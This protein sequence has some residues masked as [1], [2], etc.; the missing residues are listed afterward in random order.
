MDRRNRTAVES[1]PAGQPTAQRTRDENRIAARSLR[2]STD[3]VTDAEPPPWVDP[4]CRQHLGSAPL[5]T[6]MRSEQMSS[7]VAVRLADGR[8]VVL[9]RRDSEGG[10]EAVCLAAQAAL[11]RRGLPVATPLTPVSTTSE[12]GREVAVHAEAWVPG[13]SIMRGD[14]PGEAGLSARLLARF[15]AGL[16]DLSAIGDP[17]P[18]PY[19]LGW[20]YGDADPWPHKPWLADRDPALVPSWVTDVAR[21]VTARIID[22]DLPRVLGHGDWEAQNLRWDSSTPVVVHDWDSLAL[23][24]EAAVVGAASGAFASAEVP[25]LAPIASSL[26]FL[27]AYQRERNRTFSDQE[28]QVAWAASLWPAAHNARGELLFGHPPVASV[29]LGDQYVARL[30]LAGA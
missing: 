12:G 8:P 23:V 18:P 28:M 25:T 19:W 15:M 27:D 7:V 2:L 6:L 17:D 3:A 5:E 20:A 16:A 24:P 9:K 1:A 10:R 11:A 4:W 13:G 22:A 14:S 21:R 26:A 30:L 29:R